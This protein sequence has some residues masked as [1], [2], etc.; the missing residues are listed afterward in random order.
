MEY[1]FD[2]MICD[3]LPDIFQMKHKKVYLKSKE[4]GSKAL[5]HYNAKVDDGRSMLYKHPK[6]YFVFYFNVKEDTL[7]GIFE[8]IDYKYN[9]ISD[10][11]YKA[12]FKC[13]INVYSTHGNDFDVEALKRR[14][15]IEMIVNE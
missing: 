2:D 11:F 8:A 10:D 9:A 6:D 7:F 15:T 3:V 14:L 5:L 13:G 1:S 12:L 4:F